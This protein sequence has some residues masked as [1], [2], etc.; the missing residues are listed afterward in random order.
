MGPSPAQLADSLRRRARWVPSAR[1][2]VPSRQSEPSML[3]GAGAPRG[4]MAEVRWHAMTANAF[5]APP[6]PDR[7]GCRRATCSRPQAGWAGWRR[8]DYIAIRPAAPSAAAERRRR[9]AKAAHLRRC[10][11]RAK[12]PPSAVSTGAEAACLSRAPCAAL[13]AIRERDDPAQPVNYTEPIPACDLDD[14]PNTA[15]PGGDFA[16]RAIVDGLRLAVT[17]TQWPLPRREA[18]PLSLSPAV[19]GHRTAPVRSGGTVL[20]GAT[21]ILER[22]YPPIERQAHPQRDSQI[23]AQSAPHSSRPQAAAPRP[24]HGLRE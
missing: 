16:D 13:C 8:S 17:R 20:S 14:I 4:S 21:Q 22:A 24:P 11:G 2:T 3:G 5:S 12:A 10:G 1:A 15:R 7:G 23:S 6:D 19:R 9:R 18:G